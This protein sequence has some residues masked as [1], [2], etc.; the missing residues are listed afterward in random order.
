MDSEVK[1]ELVSA[2]VSSVVMPLVRAGLSHHFNM[3]QIE[4]RE[5]LAI[6]KAERQSEGMRAMAKAKGGGGTRPVGQV[7][8]VSQNFSAGDVY[9][10]LAE[11]KRGTDCQ[12]C[13]QAAQS[14]IE[15]A[16]PDEARQGYDELRSYE[17]EVERIEGQQIGEAQAKEIVDGLIEQ[18]S[19]V[20]RYL[21]Q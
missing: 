14:L 9:D 11:L 20:P 7:E 17:R 15:N 5:K 19:V 6:E 21:S 16:P 10:E 13:R 1:K 3:K 8:P 18:W 2:G 4:K 12:F